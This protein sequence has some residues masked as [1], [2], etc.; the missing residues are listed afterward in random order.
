MLEEEMSEER[1]IVDRDGVSDEAV[2]VLGA[3]LALRA[4]KDPG[5][6]V[7]EVSHV[8]GDVRLVDGRVPAEHAT[9]HPLPIRLHQEWN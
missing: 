6:G 3:V 1:G 5:V 7:V 9:V 4:L 8:R 2:L